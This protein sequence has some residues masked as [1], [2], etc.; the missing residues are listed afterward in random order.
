[1]ELNVRAVVGNRHDVDH[2]PTTQ[3][4]GAHGDVAGELPVQA[5]AV[6]AR[7]ERTAV[8]WRRARFVKRRRLRLG[9]PILLVGVK[10]GRAIGWL[11]KPEV[12]GSIPV[13]SIPKRLHRFDARVRVAVPRSRAYAS[14]AARSTSVEGSG[15]LTLC[16]GRPVE[17]VRR[18]AQCRAG[19]EMKRNGG[20]PEKLPRSALP[21]AYIATGEIRGSGAPGLGSRPVWA[22]PEPGR[23]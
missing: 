5:P 8:Q 12:T 4:C 20:R 15:G 6:P 18:S 7:C 3:A 2:T 13:R 9:M 23:C 21:L 16:R 19:G 11:C 22:G 1:M 14:A 17:F 10:R